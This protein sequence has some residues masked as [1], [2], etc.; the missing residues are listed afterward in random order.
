MFHPHPA[1][2]IFDDN[3]WELLYHGRSPVIPQTG[4]DKDGNRQKLG[5]ISDNR[6]GKLKKNSLLDWPFQQTNYLTL[7]DN[8]RKDN[9]YGATK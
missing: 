3:S 7:L 9:F 8:D 2:G 4:Q 5:K 1:Q 6:N